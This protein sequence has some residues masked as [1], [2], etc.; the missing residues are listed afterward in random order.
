[1]GELRLST[2][3]NKIQ[4]QIKTD[5]SERG[6]T[7]MNVHAPMVNGN[8]FIAICMIYLEK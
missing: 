8:T 6:D 1:M 2:I 3:G 7:V 4:S 5:L